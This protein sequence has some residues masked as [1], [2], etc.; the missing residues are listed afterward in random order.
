[1]PNFKTR[2]APQ[3][4]LVV[5]LN[6]VNA[7]GRRPTANLPLDSLNGFGIALDK[8]VHPAIGEIGHPPAHTL[9]L[10]GLVRKETEP[11]ALHTAAHPEPAA[12][13]HRDSIR[14]IG[15][16]LRRPGVPAADHGQAMGRSSMFR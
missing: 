2:V 6:G 5:R 16:A 8:N 12:H 9:D 15:G 14:K 3:G 10:G 13:E 11:H 1:V 7:R 4:R